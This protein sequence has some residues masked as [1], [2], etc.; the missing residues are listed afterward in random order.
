[1]GLSVFNHSGVNEAKGKLQLILLLSDSSGF[2]KNKFLSSFPFIFTISF[3]T[4]NMG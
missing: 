1:M 4:G 2:N 3:G